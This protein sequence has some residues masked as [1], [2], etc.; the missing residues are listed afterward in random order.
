MRELAIIPTDRHRM[1]PEG[2]DAGRDAW[3][4]RCHGSAT[5]FQRS[6]PRIGTAQCHPHWIADNR[7][8]ELNYRESGMLKKQNPGYRLA[9]SY[10]TFTWQ[11][12]NLS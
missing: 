4:R 1:L 6:F 11:D 7:D 2:N 8:T 5:G 12:H 9:F 3:A 10:R